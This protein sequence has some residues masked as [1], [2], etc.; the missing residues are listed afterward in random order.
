MSTTA[1]SRGT[2][3]MPRFEDVK[4]DLM[5]GFF[6]LNPATKDGWAGSQWIVLYSATSSAPHGREMPTTCLAYA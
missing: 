5:E 2:P 6:H 1:I 4:S 3:I